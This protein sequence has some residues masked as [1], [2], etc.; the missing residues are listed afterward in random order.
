MLIFAFREN[1]HK[2]TYETNKNCFTENFTYRQSNSYKICAKA[3]YFH[4]T[5]FRKI[6]ENLLSFA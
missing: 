5:K 4:K 6:F 2:K 3:K 1:I